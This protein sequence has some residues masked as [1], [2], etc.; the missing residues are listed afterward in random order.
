MKPD[1]RSKRGTGVVS[2]LVPGHRTVGISLKSCAAASFTRDE[3]CSTVSLERCGVLVA[4]INE[5]NWSQRFDLMG[6]SPESPEDEPGIKKA[7]ENLKAIIDHEIKNG[8]PANRIII[9]G[10]SQAASN[11]AN[12]DIAILQ[13][14]GEMD[15]MIPVQIGALTSEK[16][17]CVVN[18]QRVIFKTYPGMM[19]NSCPQQSQ[20]SSGVSF[21]CS[22]LAGYRYRRCELF[23]SLV[24]AGL[25]S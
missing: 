6:L 18:P 10:F 15:P 16:L 11:T 25:L 19:H 3:R 17:K 21:N 2:S 13:C 22:H 8:I 12:K 23:C 24:Q 14:H 7:S 5:N 20:G 9:G 4:F 1:K